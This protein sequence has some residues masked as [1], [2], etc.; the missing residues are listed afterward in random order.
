LTKGF[1]TIESVPF[2]RPS[3]G[4]SEI[5]QVATVL[6]SGWLTTGPRVRQF[7]E[8]FAAAVGARHA[9][10]VNSCTA[11]LHL[12]VEALGLSPGAGVLIPT[13]TFAATGEIL[14]YLGAVPILVDCDPVTL[15]MDL[16][17]AARKIAD[18]RAGRLPDSIPP[19][20]P[21]VGIIPVHVGGLLMDPETMSSWAR[22][23]GLW[24][25]EDAAHAFP[26]ASRSGPG[27]AWRRCGEDT[28][29]VSC[30][31]FYAN[32]TIT[33][34]E[35]GMAV[36]NDAAL[37]ERMRLMSLHGLSRD[38]WDR[39]SGGRSWDYRIIAPGYKYNLTDIAAAL[40]IAQLARAERMR[41]ERE[42][43]ARRYRESFARI[44]EVDIPADDPNRIHSWHLY[45]IRLRLDLLTID[46]NSFI[47][48][49]K[50]AGVG[51]SVHW[52]PLHLHPYYQSTFGWRG[53]D[54]PVATETWKRLISLPI[55]PGLRE[56]EIEFVVGVVE[57]LC[58]RYRT[59]R[60]YV[61]EDVSKV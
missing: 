7:E 23:E 18:L 8:E 57:D 59:P 32:K 1:V 35:G 27:M 29:A 25:V 22:G 14:R 33:T 44:E 48:K 9:V 56:E 51:C 43:V 53:E 2:F 20:T 4:D 6:R 3:V 12:A 5:D 10:A 40:G 36:T 28:A 55:F 26:A 61:S 24:T 41:Q 17:N 47:D 60:V 13:M 15:N 38:A 50:D 19:D 42:T 49:L 52:R 54:F 58:A 39:Y 16:A 11:A 34:G 46:R 31:S 37:A 30:F 21:V 45:P